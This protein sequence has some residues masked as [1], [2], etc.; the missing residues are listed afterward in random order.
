VILNLVKSLLIRFPRLKPFYI[1]HMNNFFTTRKLYDELYKQ[2]VGANGTAKA[3][4]DIPKEL[5]YL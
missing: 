5:A 1:L 2:E 4:S 3:G